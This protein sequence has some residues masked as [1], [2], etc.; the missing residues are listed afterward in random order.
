MRYLIVALL[1]CMNSSASLIDKLDVLVSLA[2]D[3]KINENISGAK[4]SWINIAKLKEFNKE[5]WCLNYK[6]PFNS[7]NG[8]LKLVKHDI[9]TESYF[10]KTEFSIKKIQTLK[11]TRVE[12]GFNLILN[13]KTKDFTQIPDVEI[14]SNNGVSKSLVNTIGASFLVSHKD[15]LIC[16]DFNRDCSERVK[17]KCKLCQYGWFSGA[18]SMCHGATVKYCGVSRC[19]QRNMPAC[20][21]GEKH[22]DIVALQ[23]CQNDST[24]GFCEQDLI[25][26]CENGQL[27]CR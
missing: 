6:V 23:G 15:L 14:L 5:Q 18:A 21:R 24:S 19:G 17:N 16:H 7:T 11:V 2:V 25:I 12:H 27:Y 8:E 22:S 10:T 13:N 4:S 26:V 1:I 20:P 3:I 9:C